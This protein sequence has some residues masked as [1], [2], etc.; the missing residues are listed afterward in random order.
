MRKKKLCTILLIF[1]TIFFVAEIIHGCNQSENPPDG[2][3][4]PSETDQLKSPFS[5]DLVSEMK[6]RGLYNLY[7]RSCHGES[8]LRDGAAGKDLIAKPSNFHDK[9]VKTQT[10]GALFWKL[11]NGNKSMPSFKISC[12]MNSAG[13]SFLMMELFL[14]LLQ[15]LPL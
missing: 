1:C 15:N 2:W 6:D 14:R 5:F 8:G 13:N 12:Q 10:D 4:A 9:R 11:G 3:K 7:C